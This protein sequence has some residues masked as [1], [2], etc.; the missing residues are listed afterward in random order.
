[1][2]DGNPQ[3]DET[4]SAILDGAIRCIYERGFSNLTT[5]CIADAAGVNEV[6][7]FRRFGN[8]A[9]VLE[10]VFA[11]EARSVDGLDIQYTGD[12]EADLTRIVSALWQLTRTRQT[13]IPVLLM[14]LPRN[15]DLQE[16]AR[17]SLAQVA[18]FTRII[19][20]YQKQGLLREDSAMMLFVTLLGPLVFAATTGNLLALPDDFNAGQYI[21]GFLFGYGR[22]L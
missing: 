10:A 7:I 18:D 21:Q 19:G 22:Y 1:M 9:A 20:Q 11:R 12:L 8:K 16:Y 15:P 6:T 14:E 5:R 17:H 2:S 13:I 4:Q 3:W